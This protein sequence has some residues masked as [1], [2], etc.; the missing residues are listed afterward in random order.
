V[1]MN[2][3]WGLLRLEPI[4]TLRRA[5][6]WLMAPPTSRQTVWSEVRG[7]AVEIRSLSDSELWITKR[8][9][10]TSR[11]RPALTLECRRRGLPDS[12]QWLTAACLVYPDATGMRIAERMFRP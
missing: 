11:V 5:W 7:R 12:A 6:L 2:T 8:A 1:T 9:L 4:R 10:F 3:P